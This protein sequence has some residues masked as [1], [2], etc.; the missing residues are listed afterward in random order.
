MLQP[1]FPLTILLV[2]LTILAAGFT[3]HLEQEARFLIAAQAILNA[4]HP[5]VLRNTFHLCWVAGGAILGGYVAVALRRIS[6]MHHI[7]R[8]FAVS[9]VTALATAPYVLTTYFGPLLSPE[10]CFLVGFLFAVAAWLGWELIGIVALR[11]KR[12]AYQRGWLG[13]KDEITGTS[14]SD[15]MALNRQATRDQG[16]TTHNQENHPCD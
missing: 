16:L 2:A 14:H 5:T 4:D 7:V 3:S 10:A 11:L 9:V 15:P 6:G 12:A 8:Y 13:I 1:Q